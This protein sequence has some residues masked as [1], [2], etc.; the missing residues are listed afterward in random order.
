LNDFDTFVKKN[1]I[2]VI[3]LAGRYESESL[4]WNSNRSVF[5]Y[6][7]EHICKKEYLSSRINSIFLLK[8]KPGEATGPH[9]FAEAA[10]QAAGT[11]DLSRYVLELD[12]KIEM[13]MKVKD[14]VA[15][16]YPRVDDPVRTELISIVNSIKLSAND[17]KLWDD[18]Q[19]YFEKTNPNFLLLLAKKHPGLTPKDLKYCCYLKMNMA[20]DDIRTLLGINQ[21]SVRTHKYRLKKKLVL[22]KD[23][24]LQSYL[25]F[26]G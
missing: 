9:S 21:E 6:P 12:Q 16:L 5:C 2:P 20:N 4:S 19:M 7:L 3:C 14:R 8:S 15:D 1:D 23:Q 22:A 17:T 25:R 10:I 18:F 13:L 24:D 26:F 11:K